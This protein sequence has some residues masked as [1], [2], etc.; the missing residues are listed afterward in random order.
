M[1]DHSLVIVIPAAYRD[2]AQNLGLSYGYDA[3]FGVAL[4]ADG[5]E[6]ATHYGLHSW[7]AAPFIQ[8]LQSQPP[9]NH[10]TYSDAQIAGLLAQYTTSVD[11]TQSY[12]NGIKVEDVV[13]VDVTLEDE[14]VV[15][16]LKDVN[17][18]SEED[19]VVDTNPTIPEENITKVKLAPVDHF[20]SVITSMGLQQI[21]G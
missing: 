12:Y 15:R 8:L 6:P 16:V 3:G 2:A 7:A 20:D 1:Y 11:A 18:V 5:L 14:T 13:E 17:D 9:Y 19:E 21:T 4:S 10:P